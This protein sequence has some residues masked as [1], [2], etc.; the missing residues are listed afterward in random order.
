M[1]PITAKSASPAYRNPPSIPVQFCVT[2]FR[3]ATEGDEFPHPIPVKEPTSPP[4]MIFPLYVVRHSTT[5]EFGPYTPDQFVPFHFAI[6]IVEMVSA[7]VKSL[8]IGRASCRE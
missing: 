1:F 5:P 2:T 6:P 4:K 3:L 8:K 7:I